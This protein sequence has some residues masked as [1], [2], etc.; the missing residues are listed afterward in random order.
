MPARAAVLVALMLA[1]GCTQDTA[2][3]SL[4]APT[5]PTTP[6]STPIPTS[7]SGRIT[8]TQTVADLL[9]Y[10]QNAVG[11]SS[12]RRPDIIARWELP[13]PLFVDASASATNVR[14]AM[15][16]WRSVTGLTYVMLTADVEPRIFVRAGTDGL[17]T[18]GARGLVDGTYADNRAR[19]GLVVV[20]PDLALCDFAQSS[21]QVIYEHELGHTIGLFDHVAG[22]GIMSGGTRASTRE[23]NMLLEL[24]RLPHG[25]HIDPD[26]TWRGVP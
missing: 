9:T 8:D 10:H 21:C 4:T 12:A 15:E 1:A 13:I 25:T 20:R 19:S 24:Y 18:A 14:Q 7:T 3:P 11:G 2:D 5:P 6:L 26:G 22:G 23:I 17:G 16:Y